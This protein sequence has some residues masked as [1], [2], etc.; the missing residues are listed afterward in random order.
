MS[1]K[2][3]DPLVFP[4]DFRFQA[5]AEKTCLEML[6][7][8]SYLGFSACAKEMLTRAAAHLAS[9]RRLGS[10]LR[11]DVTRLPLPSGFADVVLCDLPFGRQFGTV[12]GNKDP[13]LTALERQQGGVYY[14]FSV[15]LFLHCFLRNAP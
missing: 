8:A 9:L 3:G 4:K 1:K 12:E 5:C 15:S 2:T 14:D 13:P 7:S 11:G 10:L 6:P